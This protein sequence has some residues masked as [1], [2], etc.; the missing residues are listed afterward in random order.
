MQHQE[1]VDAIDCRKGQANY[2]LHSL[3][4]DFANG[5]TR[6]CENDTLSGCT[7]STS[8][9]LTNVRFCL[10]LKRDVCIFITLS[11]IAYSDKKNNL[12]LIG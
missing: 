7:E 11:D 10:Y 3:Y 9:L 12:S 1:C 2:V 5:Y 8:N 6:L 4:K